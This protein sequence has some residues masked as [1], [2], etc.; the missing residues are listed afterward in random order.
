MSSNGWRT[1]IVKDQE[2]LYYEN[3]NIV[4][5][6]EHENRFP[7]DQTKRIMIVQPRGSITLPLLNKLSQNHIDVLICNEKFL[8]AFSVSSLSSGSSGHV[9][10]QM[11]WSNQSKRDVWADIVRN[12]IRMQIAALVEFQIDVPKQMHEYVKN[13]YTDDST[14]REAMASRMYFDLLFGK[15]F[16]RHADDEINAAL[17]YGYSIL[18]SA[19]A[20]SISLH[21]YLNAIG[22]HHCGRDNPV[23]L[24]CDIME[25]FRPFIDVIVYSNQNRKLDWEYKKELIAVTEGICQYKEQNMLVENAIEYYVLDITK[26][27]T[28]GKA[29][30]GDIKLGRKKRSFAFNV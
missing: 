25:P 1:L 29:Y 27:L 30:M 6:G 5:C 10:D 28:D 9:M 20:R 17:N 3:G 12:K 13:I 19:A 26:T 23:N 14:N 15:Q 4:I 16:I 2:K 22:I 8:P 24:A 7:L 18:C 11:E 21:G